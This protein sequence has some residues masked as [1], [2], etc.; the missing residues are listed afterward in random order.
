MGYSGGNNTVAGFNE[1]VNGWAT[2]TLTHGST[3]GGPA[4]AKRV[5]VNADWS[6]DYQ[7]TD[8]L[9]IIDE[10]SYD[11]WRIPS[12]W[13]TAETNLF[14]TPPHAAGQVG[15]LLP[16]AM[17]T[18][19][20]FAAVCP[21]APYNGTNCPQHNT[22]SGADVTDELVSQFLG[23]NIRSN[24]IELRYD[25]ARRFSAYAGYLFTARTIADF[26]STFDTGEIYFPGGTGG[27]AANH[28]LAARADCA[29]VS[30]A[31][32]AGCTLNANGSIQEGSPANLVPEA[33]ND[34]SRNIYEIHENAGLAGVSARPIDT[35]RINA[36][37]VFGYND[38][39]F[40]RISPRQE[41]SYKV[42]AAYTPAP[43]ATVSGAVDINENRDNVA[44]V[45]NI[46]HS[47][48]YSF[49]DD[50]RARSEAV[51]GFRLQLHGYLHT[52]RNLLPRHGINGLHHAVSCASGDVPL[53]TLSFYSSK[54]HYAYGDVMW[55]PYKRVTTMLGYAGSIVRG[56]TTFL[57]PLTPTG[58]LDFNY[59]KPTASL[60]V[61]IYRGVTYKT[62][63]NYYGYNDEG[64]ARPAGLSALPS[65]SFNGSNVTFSVKYAF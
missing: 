20:N 26:S 56:N 50:T 63:W 17:V 33:G 8:K 35:L 25:F 51:G 13:A 55:K 37:F 23:Q 30:G 6:G 9:N 27:T 57:N 22:S 49:C 14:A 3:T 59:L 40:T 38:N 10:F 36:D 45:N 47:R 2:R 29:V 48:A 46:E 16:V 32:P 43:W 34:T 61:D 19:A 52:D 44:T 62:A 41:Q 21:T 7:L 5:S 64:V 54:D 24:T 42:H 4:E 65:Q 53:G 1:S 11:N 12:M 39:S 60:A 28:F 31:L 15:L 58:T 18:P